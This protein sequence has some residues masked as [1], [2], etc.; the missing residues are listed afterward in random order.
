MAAQ[1]TGCGQVVAHEPVQRQMLEHPYGRRCVRLVNRRSPQDNL[2]RPAG[3]LEQHPEQP[4]TGQQRAELIGLRDTQR[5]R[6]RS[7]EQLEGQHE[8]HRLSDLDD[9]AAGQ[10]SPPQPGN[11]I[12]HGMGMARQGQGCTNGQQRHHRDP[13]HEAD[14]HRQDQRDHRDRQ[15]DQIELQPGDPEEGEGQDTFDHALPGIRKIGRHDRVGKSVGQAD[16]LAHHCQGRSRR[17]H[18]HQQAGQDL[19]EGVA[20][21]DGLV[22]HDRDAAR[23]DEQDVDSG[24]DPQ[25][26]LP[27]PF[28]VG[29]LGDVG[30]CQQA[31]GEELAQR[32][33]DLLDQRAEE[34]GD[35]ARDQA[36]DVGEDVPPR[37]GVLDALLAHRLTRRRRRPG[38]RLRRG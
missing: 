23:R 38:S 35:R 12:G 2:Q 37:G 15:Q 9:Q 22:A 1:Q 27:Q 14:H 26:G 20:G 19:F 32:L 17:D 6:A 7:E 16:R 8:R 21:L 24:G 10:P 31:V 13:H 34:R 29:V 28:D 33:H 18:S 30:G 36:R 25:H 4:E 5:R 3:N 11:R